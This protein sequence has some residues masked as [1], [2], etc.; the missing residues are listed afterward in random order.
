MQ[1]GYP[2]LTEEDKRKIFGGNLG[3]LLGI[4]TSKRRVPQKK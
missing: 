3:R 1:Y 2:P 4:D